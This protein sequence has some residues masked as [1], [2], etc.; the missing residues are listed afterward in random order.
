MEA[1]LPEEADYPDRWT[2]IRDVAVLQVKL[3]VDGLRDLVLVPASLFAGIISLASGSKER[4]SPHFYRLISMG[5]QSEIWINLFKAYEHAPPEV[6]R[7]HSFA[8]ADMDEFVDKFESFVVDEYQRGGVTR[9][10]KE[11]IDKALNSI[12][13]ADKE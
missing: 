11:R 9:A 4:P 12:H 13:R 6:K 8:V 3:L 5:K 7:E 10:A 2:L 1:N